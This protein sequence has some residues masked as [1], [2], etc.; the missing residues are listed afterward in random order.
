M[1][2]SIDWARRLLRR[3]PSKEPE[4]LLK[5]RSYPDPTFL[6]LFFD[7]LDELIFHD[8]R[9]GLRWALVAPDLALATPDTD[10]RQAH[11]ERIVKAFAIL[12]SAR[13][14]VGDYPAADKAYAAALQF[15]DSA[16]I[17][18][19]VRADTDRRLSTLRASQSRPDE[20][21][22]LATGAVRILRK[23]ASTAV[24]AAAADPDDAQAAEVVAATNLLLGKALLAWGY[25][26]AEAQGRY[27]E[28]VDA[29]GE[30]LL[31]DGN[32][33]GSVAKRIHA[34]A[35]YNLATAIALSSHL[36]DK[37]RAMSYVRQAR[38]IVKGQKRSVARYRLCWVEA[39]LWGQA[40][41][42]A[43]AE[44]LYRLALEGFQALKLPWDI[45]LVGLD[46]G[47]LLHLCGDWP[48]L[49]KLA[50]ET[51]ERFRL[52]AAETRAIAALS[53]W[54]D[55]VK[56]QRNE[57]LFELSEKARQIIAAGVFSGRPRKRKKR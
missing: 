29:F 11:R 5:S 12:G 49:E 51:F 39:F 57:E 56:A 37:R 40:G 3:L 43:K 36:G 47:A 15:A 7:W 45:A 52:L 32:T 55:A 54:N 16:H 41:S 53:Q 17:S 48:E 2:H 9:E 4:A 35:C 34:A 28:S 44:R 38:E 26:M 30:A 6:S 13:R 1:T 14:A 50:G 27:G 46:L 18:E 20:A 25:V 8:P 19:V 22:E 31:L 42:H 33:K 23:T 24:A 10:G 21:L